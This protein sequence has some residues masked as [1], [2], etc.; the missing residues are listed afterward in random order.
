M[1]VG[2]GGGM[3]GLYPPSF[4]A[5]YIIKLKYYLNGAILV[6]IKELNFTKDVLQYRPVGI[7]FRLRH[8]VL[9]FN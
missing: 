2:N 7:S 1:G 3:G 5:N 4:S 6:T 8:C 9:C